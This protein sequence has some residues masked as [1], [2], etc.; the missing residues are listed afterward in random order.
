M[1][2]DE[3]FLD[4]K[5][6]LMNVFL[7]NIRPNILDVSYSIESLEINIQVVLLEDTELDSFSLKELIDELKG[8][9]VKL[10]LI[11]IS[12]MDYNSNK[13]NWMP[14]GYEW[15]S[16]VVLSKWGI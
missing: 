13:G 1:K 9:T 14:I 11:F 10:N 6:I 12:K 16:I 15:R 8:F 2:Y 7:L 5:Y 3:K 4:V